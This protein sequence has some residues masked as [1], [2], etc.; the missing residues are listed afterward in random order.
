MVNQWLKESIPLFVVKPESNLSGNS[1]I[2]LGLI[3]TASG[4]NQL[5]G[6]SVTQI[7]EPTLWFAH[8]S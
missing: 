2:E 5:A 1:V 4:A 7:F 8:E 6:L 3:G